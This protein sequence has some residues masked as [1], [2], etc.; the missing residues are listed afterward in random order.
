MCVCVREGVCGCVCMHNMCS[1]LRGIIK[2][3]I[4]PIFASLPS[5]ARQGVYT[6]NGL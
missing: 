3:S 1:V 2:M 5:V 4:S 6:G